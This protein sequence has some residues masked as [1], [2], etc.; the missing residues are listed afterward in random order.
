MRDKNETICFCM[1]ITYGEIL[2]AI[3][4]GATTPEMVTDKTDAGLACGGC[5]E[6]IEDIFE[7]L[8]KNQ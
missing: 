1:D 3:N 7:E 8:N 6:T 4:D 5:I 2:K